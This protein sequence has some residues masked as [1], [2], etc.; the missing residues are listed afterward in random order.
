MLYLSIKNSGSES[1][2]IYLRD[3]RQSDIQTYI[4]C[5]RFEITSDVSD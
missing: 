3:T 2:G 4:M 1:S 5:D